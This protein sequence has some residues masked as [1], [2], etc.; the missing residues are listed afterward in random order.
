MRYRYSNLLALAV[1]IAVV[2]LSA[3]FAFVQ[4]R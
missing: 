2:L 4:T 3:V 1:G